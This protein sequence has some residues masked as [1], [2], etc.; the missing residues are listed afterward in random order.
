MEKIFLSLIDEIAKD[1]EII[2][3]D[4]RNAESNPSDYNSWNKLAARLLQEE[5][6]AQAI[7]CYDKAIQLIILIHGITEV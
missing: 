4:V 7:D 1:N 5:Y 3:Q 6:Y 2:R